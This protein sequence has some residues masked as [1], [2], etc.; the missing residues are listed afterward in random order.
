MVP[1]AWKTF[2]NKESE[3]VWQK[4]QGL[5][6]NVYW[7]PYTAKVWWDDLVGDHV[8]E[9]TRHGLQIINLIVEQN[10]NS[11]LVQVIVTEALLFV[12]KM[13]AEQMEQWQK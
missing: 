3:S 13:W 8:T 10:N 12:T 4:L 1:N 5:D 9:T 2:Y 7:L 11:G 6:L